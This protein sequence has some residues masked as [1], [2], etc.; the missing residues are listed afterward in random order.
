MR[1]E[2][3]SFN[4]FTEWP[5]L[6]TS[7]LYF[8]F[9]LTNVVGVGK[10]KESSL[11]FLYQVWQTFSLINFIAGGPQKRVWAQI[12]NLSHRLTTVSSS[13][14]FKS[15]LRRSAAVMIIVT[16]LLF[17]HRHHL[18]LVKRK[19]RNNL[20]ANKG[21]NNNHHQKFI[22]CRTDGSTTSPSCLFGCA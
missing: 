8:I 10:N 21:H 17:Y 6:T 20:I 3:I 14:T 12:P 15:T 18:W 4:V 2:R 7:I 13:M 22:Y 5:T 19:G 9:N 16:G 1:D 11:A